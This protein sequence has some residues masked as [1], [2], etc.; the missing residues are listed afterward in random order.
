MS[1][2]VARIASDHRC[3]RYAGDARCGAARADH[4]DRTDTLAAVTVL[5]FDTDA[6]TG[7]EPA[8]ASTRAANPTSTRRAAARA[9]PGPAWRGP[10][11][12]RR[13]ATSSAAHRAG[14]TGSTGETPRIRRAAAQ[15]PALSGAGG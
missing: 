15:V 11:R 9:N 8:V 13:A 10:R 3:L 2:I 5:A 7:A 1:K 12:A 14:G 6:A 4:G